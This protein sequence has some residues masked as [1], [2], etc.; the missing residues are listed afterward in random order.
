M[1]ILAIIG[2][3]V[4]RWKRVPPFQGLGSLWTVDP[5][6][7][8]RT[9][10]ALGYLSFG[11]SALFSRS[12]AARQQGILRQSILHQGILLRGEQNCARAFLTLAGRDSTLASD[13][14]A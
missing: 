6:R 8:S 5:G 14:K 3:V 2:S 10:S 13:D 1:S 7:R 4:W 9:R 11:L 12:T